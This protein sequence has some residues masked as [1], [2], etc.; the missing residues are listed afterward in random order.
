MI[1]YAKVKYLFSS[2]GYVTLVLKWA[3]MQY[4]TNKLC[5]NS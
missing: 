1:S 2:F 5:S 4:H 3:E